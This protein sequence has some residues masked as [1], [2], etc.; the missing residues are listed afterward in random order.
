M[1]F[2]YPARKNSQPHLYT[3]RTN[4][5][6]FAVLRRNGRLQ[7]IGIIAVGVI[8]FLWLIFHIV[9]ASNGSE[10]RK[11][12]AARNAPKAVIVTVFDD[13]TNE[14]H[15]EAIRE[16]RREYAARHGA[17]NPVICHWGDKL[18]RWMRQSTSK[19]E[20]ELDHT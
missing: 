5:R 7:S 20:K 16:N 12:Y 9:A 8:G 11:S 19:A 13:G 1:H 18:M 15:R 2:A 6:P 10:G 14:A 17:Y 4:N 3:S